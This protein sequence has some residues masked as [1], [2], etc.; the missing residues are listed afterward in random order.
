MND[1]NKSQMTDHDFIM[2]YGCKPD[3]YDAKGAVEKHAQLK[4]DVEVARFNQAEHLARLEEAK[5][6]TMTLLKTLP[7]KKTIP[8]EFYAAIA[9][10][11]GPASIIHAIWGVVTM[12]ITWVLVVKGW[13]G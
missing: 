11:V 7:C 9:K 8:V 12:F 3:S 1:S 10:V 2:T 4:R 5:A 13:R 6:Q